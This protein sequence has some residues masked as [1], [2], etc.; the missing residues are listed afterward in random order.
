M[1]G[2]IIASLM[3]IA[4][5]AASCLPEVTDITRLG[6]EYCVSYIRNVWSYAQVII[7]NPRNVALF[8]TVRR[9]HVQTLKL[10][11]SCTK[12]QKIGNI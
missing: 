12:V 5:S 8:E 4:M 1:R 7:E 2:D 9:V 11:Y 6:D 3:K 10:T